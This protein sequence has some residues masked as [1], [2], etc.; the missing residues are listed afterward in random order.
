MSKKRKRKASKSKI[1]IFI[2]LI[3]FGSV[4]AALGY[5]CLTNILKIQKMENEKKVLQ[6]QLVS[7]QEEKELLET[8]ILKL[9]DPD[10]IAKYVREKYFYS[11]DG[12]F[13]LRLE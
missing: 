3:I 9:E 2:S 13:I 11:K 12:E 8:D 1:R 7:L 4:L 10:Y 5:N 6:E